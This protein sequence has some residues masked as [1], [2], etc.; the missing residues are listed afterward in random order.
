MSAGELHRRLASAMALTALVA[1]MG[2][3][4][5]SSPST[6]IAALLLLLS[7]FWQPGVR[8][9][10]PLVFAWRIGALVLSLGAG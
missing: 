9:A 10:G 5:I 2:G 8:I 1:F 6:P 3:A 7:V 4:G